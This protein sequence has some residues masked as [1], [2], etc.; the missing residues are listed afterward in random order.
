M[1][2]DQ[3]IWRE[4]Q[5]QTVTQLPAHIQC[6]N[7]TVK[8]ALLTVDSVTTSG[9]MRTSFPSSFFSPV[10]GVYIVMVKQYSDVNVSYLEISQIS[11]KLMQLSCTLTWTRFQ[12]ILIGFKVYCQYSLYHYSHCKWV[13]RN[14]KHMFRRLSIQPIFKYISIVFLNYTH[15][16][17][18]CHTVVITKDKNTFL[19]E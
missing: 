19:V 2:T 15:W 9:R 17:Y 6:W 11:G 16:K 8:S 12:K 7:I 5:K 1:I 10:L 3:K 14:V 13:L 18:W 4:K